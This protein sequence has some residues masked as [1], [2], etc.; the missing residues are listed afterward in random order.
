MDK[1]IALCVKEICADILDLNPAAIDK[2]LAMDNIESW[3][4]LSHINLIAALEEKWKI[5]FDV[6]EIETM[7]TFQKIVEKIKQKI[8]Q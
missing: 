6:E 2:H 3:D 1:D 5:T 8:N 7:T 4:S